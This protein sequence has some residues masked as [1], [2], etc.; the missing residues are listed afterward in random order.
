MVDQFIERRAETPN[1]SGFRELSRTILQLQALFRSNIAGIS[2]RIVLE[3]KRLG[4]RDLESELEVFNL[5]G[6]VGV[7]EITRIDHGVRDILLVQE[8]DNVKHSSKGPSNVNLLASVVHDRSQQGLGV[9]VDEIVVFIEIRRNQT[10]RVRILVG[11]TFHETKFIVEMR[12]DAIGFD[13]GVLEFFDNNDITG[14]EVDGLVPRSSNVG[15]VTNELHKGIVVRWV[16][17]ESQGFFVHGLLDRQRLALGKLF[18]HL[19]ELASLFVQIRDDFLDR[20]ALGFIAVQAAFSEF[21][22]HFMLGVLSGECKFAG[23]A[24]ETIDLLIVVFTEEVERGFTVQHFVENSTKGPD[25][26]RLF[27]SMLTIFVLGSRFR[28]HVIDR[29][30]SAFL[31]ELSFVSLKH[32]GHVEIENL[33]SVSDKKNVF[34]FQISVKNILFVQFS[35]AEDNLTK[36]GENVERLAR[37]QVQGPVV[38][39]KVTKTDFAIFHNDS[40]VIFLLFK[41]LELHNVR[42]ADHTLVDGEFAVQI[43][44]IF[45]VILRI[46][47][48]GGVVDFGWDFVNQRDFVLSRPNAEH[49][50]DVVNTFAD[51][52]KLVFIVSLSRSEQNRGSKTEKQH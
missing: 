6:L 1:I 18:N 3:N 26:R 20:R 7:P 48:L 16:V 51:F 50:V 15:V 52:Q 45:F 29:S 39:H 25:I 10:K 47:K 27:V 17:S 40:R 49:P 46:E 2:K 31:E 36:R 4:V 24:L 8:T 14:F 23:F 44:F 42:G 30:F 12:K 43:H 33:Q 5:E 11:K 28:G 9:L 13:L 34:R 21:V 22:V 37:I 41:I 32:E 35:D 38:L 19:G